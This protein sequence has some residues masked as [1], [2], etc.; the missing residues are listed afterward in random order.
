M[1]IA[2]PILMGASEVGPLTDKGG[3]GW[4]KEKQASQEM[5]DFGGSQRDHRRASSK[6]VLGRAFETFLDADPDQK[7][8]GEQDQGD[9]T[10]PARED[11][12][13]ILVQTEILTG[14]QVFFDPPAGANG[15]HDGGQGS[16][17]RS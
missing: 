16:G 14:F 13:F 17:E 11:A 15:L 8:V 10:I 6:Q 5:T 9:V 4:G 1:V 2:R 7:G 3:G 12:H